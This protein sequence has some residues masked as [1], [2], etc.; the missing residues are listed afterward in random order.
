LPPVR[1]AAEVPAPE[2]ES[3]YIADRLTGL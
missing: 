1:P 2:A 3:E